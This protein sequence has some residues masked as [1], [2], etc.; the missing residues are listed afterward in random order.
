VTV[1]LY[2]ASGAEIGKD[3]TDLSRLGPGESGRFQIP[4]T[5]TNVARFTITAVAGQ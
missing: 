5:Q 4:V 3:A 2:G 1:T